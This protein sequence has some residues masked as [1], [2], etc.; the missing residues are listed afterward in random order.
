M[1]ISYHASPMASQLANIICIAIAICRPTIYYLLLLV[2]I[3]GKNLRKTMSYKKIK[4][5]IL[6]SQTT[7]KKYLIEF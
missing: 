4:S 3:I 1:P 6:K 2:M 5:Y 7:L